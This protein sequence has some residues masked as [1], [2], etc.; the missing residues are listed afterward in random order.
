[1]KAIPVDLQKNSIH[2]LHHHETHTLKELEVLAIANAS[3]LDA[4]EKIN[5]ALHE[6]S[7]FN[8][9]MKSLRVGG[10]LVF[11]VTEQIKS[12]MLHPS[13]ERL[14]AYVKVRQ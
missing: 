11:G 4:C 8:L 1:M 14:S 7:T 9:D 13:N 2:N 6:L 12:R 5:A 10:N 3:L